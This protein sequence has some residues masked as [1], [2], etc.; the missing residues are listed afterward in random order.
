MRAEEG[1]N[2]RSRLGNDVVDQLLWV[3]GSLVWI[4]NGQ[5]RLLAAG[6]EVSATPIVAVVVVIVVVVVVQRAES[7]DALPLLGL[8]G[9]RLGR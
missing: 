1:S 3:V 2:L 6:K 7:G 5:P 4:L 9:C 8:L